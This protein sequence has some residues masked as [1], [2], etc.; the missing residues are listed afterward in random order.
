MSSTITKPQDSPSP[1]ILMFSRLEDMNMAITICRM[2]HELENW[3]L[4]DR[5]SRSSPNGNTPASSHK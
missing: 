3:L 5:L 2:M 4:E 1:V